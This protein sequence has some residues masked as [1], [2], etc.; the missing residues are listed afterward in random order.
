MWPS[1]WP[2]G[3]G[4]AGPASAAEPESAATATWRRRG[5][6]DEAPCLQRATSASNHLCLY[7]HLEL[8]L[9]LCLHMYMLVCGYTVTYLCTYA[10][11]CN[12]EPCLKIWA[13]LLRLLLGALRLDSFC[14]G[15]KGSIRKVAFLNWKPPIHRCS[16]AHPFGYAH[17]RHS[18]NSAQ[19][20]DIIVDM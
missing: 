20:C 13:Q 14:L 18:C 10:Y 15:R 19:R 4:V 9:D 2:M 17:F 7:L 11:I 16:C 3:L 12:H 5:T 8:Y 1:S 6:L